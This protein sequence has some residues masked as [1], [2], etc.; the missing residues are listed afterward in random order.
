[1]KRICV[2][3]GSAPGTEPSYMK[4]A[5]EMGRLLVARGLGLV[6]GGGNI[7]LMGA[8]ADGVLE[9][10]GEVIGVIPHHLEAKELAHRGVTEMHVVETMLERKTL[11]ASLSDGFVSLPGGM[12]TLDE[13]FEM[14][15]WTQLKQQDKPSGLLNQNGYY[16]KLLAFLDHAVAEGF[17]KAKHR[18]LLWVD[19]DPAALLDKMQKSIPGGG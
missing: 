15:T 7:G 16:D 6:Y 13:L 9:A 12:G 1:M 5:H 17:I 18:D 10:G 11:M 3:C 2:F 8:V 19:S 4:T 14:L